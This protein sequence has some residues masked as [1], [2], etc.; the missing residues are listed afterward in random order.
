M[1]TKEKDNRLLFFIMLSIS[2]GQIFNIGMPRFA[3]KKRER[4]D[5]LSN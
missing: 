1:N 5:L 2:R 3:N 4:I